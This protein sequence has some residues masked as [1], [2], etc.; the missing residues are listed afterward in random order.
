MGDQA[1]KGGD[2]AESVMG[3][4]GKGSFQQS[5]D[6]SEAGGDAGHRGAADGRDED[7][8]DKLKDQV[9]GKDAPKEERKDAA[10]PDRGR[11]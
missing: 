3:D 1:V 7:W 2:A 4:A 8:R 11:S 5:Q 10:G 9:S 6:K